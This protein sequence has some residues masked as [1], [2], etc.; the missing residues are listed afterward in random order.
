MPCDLEEFAYLT[1][2][3]QGEAIK[4]GVLHWRSRMMKTSGALYWQLNDCWPVISWSSVDYRRRPKGLYWYTRRFFA[5]VAARVAM[6]SDGV[7]AWVI[8]DSTERV[9][10]EFLIQS[11]TVDGQERAAIREHVEVSPNCV[12]VAGP[13][14]TDMFRIDE[15]A[16]QVLVATFVED[17]KAPVRDVAFVARPVHMSIPDPGLDW[18]LAGDN[19]EF[20][21]TLTAKSFAYGVYLRLPDT[22]AE[23]S[24]NF[25]TLLAGESAEIEVANSGLNA[26][27]AARRLE[28]RWVKGGL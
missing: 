7:S 27:Q 26:S 28:V 22:E 24:D 18:E 1:Q 4:A 19:G 17:G 21:I 15:P 5:P 20:T 23:F 9:E 11:M 8:N 12:H 3:L 16:R 14:A 25:F 6:L 10:G 2:V 13:F